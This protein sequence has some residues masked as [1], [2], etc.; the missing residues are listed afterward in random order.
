M[1][2]ELVLFTDGPQ[3]AMF[4]LDECRDIANH[5][6]SQGV[7]MFTYNHNLY[8]WFNENS[9]E[10]ESYLNTWIEECGLGNSYIQFLAP[11]CNN[12]LDL[13]AQAVWLY[14]EQKVHSYLVENDP[15]Y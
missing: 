1:T 7:A 6:M 9:E 14:V 3:Q 13:K 15:N 2:K 5:G 10:I 11:K 8:E 4:D 12:H